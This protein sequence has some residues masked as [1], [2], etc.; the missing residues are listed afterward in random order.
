MK[1]RLLGSNSFLRISHTFM[2]CA[3]CQDLL[4]GADRN[5]R[6]WSS[7]VE[8]MDSLSTR[9]VTQDRVVSSG[10]SRRTEETSHLT[11][12]CPSLFVM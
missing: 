9:C 7:W 5:K 12:V 1:L 4:N 2:K 11:C 6:D 10:V 3:V 8:L